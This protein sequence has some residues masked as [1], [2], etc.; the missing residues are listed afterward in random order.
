MPMS[1]WGRKST[2]TGRESYTILQ[3]YIFIALIAKSDV[4]LIA[5]DKGELDVDDVCKVLMTT[6]NEYAN[7]G[8]RIMAN[9][10]KKNPTCFF[11]NDGLLRF[12][13]NFCI[14]G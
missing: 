13:K 7:T 12:L 9:E 14:V 10:L 2:E 5:L 4:D 6:L 8:F 3:N 1:S 11:E